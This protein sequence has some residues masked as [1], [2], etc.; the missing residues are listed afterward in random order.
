VRIAVR[1]SS[2]NGTRQPD[3]LTFNA[4]GYHDNIVQ[5]VTVEVA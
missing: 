2:R 5:S 4:S 3:K 1:A